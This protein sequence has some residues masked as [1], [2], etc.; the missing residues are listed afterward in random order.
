MP[1]PTKKVQTMIT[2]KDVLDRLS[3]VKGPDLEGDIVSLGMVGGIQ[4]DG[5]KV[6][7]SIT[8][9]AERAQELEPLRAAAQGSVERLDGVAKVMAVLTG[10]R[11]PGSA[12]VRPA[13]SPAQMASVPPPMQAQAAASGGGAAGAAEQKA[14]VP[15]IKSIIAVASGKGGVGKSTTSVNLA[16]GLQASGLKVGVLDADIYGPSMPRLLESLTARAQMA[17]FSIRWRAL[18]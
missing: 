15:G 4:I 18:G 8:V 9:P 17:A 14:G 10:E 12:P 1:A 3:K 2:E 13:P 5:D 7:F 11:K 6:I 16:L